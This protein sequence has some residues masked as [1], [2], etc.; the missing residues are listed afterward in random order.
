MS[1]SE[2]EEVEVG[3]SKSSLASSKQKA[4]TK[5][6]KKAKRSHSTSSSHDVSAMRDEVGALDW[7]DDEY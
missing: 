4:A 2:D 7:S 6:A 1:Q 3:R 5:G